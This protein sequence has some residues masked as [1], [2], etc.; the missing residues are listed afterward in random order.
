MLR[1]AMRAVVATGVLAALA[2][3][4]SVPAEAQASRIERERG[5]IMLRMLR[6]DIEE[7]YYDPTYRG[8]D[9][10]ARVAKAAAGICSASEAGRLLTER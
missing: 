4:A 3:I 7:Q 8:I 5:H 9:L 2:P 10:Y 1:R 6:R